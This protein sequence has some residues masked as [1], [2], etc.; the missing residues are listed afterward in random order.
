[1]GKLYYKELYPS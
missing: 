1:V